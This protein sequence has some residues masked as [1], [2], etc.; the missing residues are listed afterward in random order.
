MPKL[1]QHNT[2]TRNSNVLR[3][4]RNNRN[5]LR[6]TPNKKTIQNE[7]N[8]TTS[9]KME[10]N[11]FEIR[12]EILILLKNQKL[13]N[14]NFDYIDKEFPYITDYFMIEPKDIEE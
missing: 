10:D 11:W 4:M 6:R 1:Q 5:N 3:K 7:R 13:F 2:R 9:I 14:T 8:R 12:Q